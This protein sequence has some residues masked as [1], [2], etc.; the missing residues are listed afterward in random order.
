[1][2]AES[3]AKRIGSPLMPT[4][5]RLPT[6]HNTTS[7]MFLME[8]GSRKHRSGEETRTGRHSSAIS[9]CN[10]QSL[11]S[12]T[13]RKVIEPNCDKVQN[14]ILDISGPRFRLLENTIANDMRSTVKVWTRCSC[15]RSNSSV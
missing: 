7:K 8:R 12:K 5:E 9:I 6:H 11:Q 4:Q 15:T 1:M 10:A 13:L 3:E 2:P 14:A